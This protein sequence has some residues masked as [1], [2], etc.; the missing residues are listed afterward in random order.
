MVHSRR[1]S[2]HGHH[3][4]CHHR[5][6]RKGSSVIPYASGPIAPESISELNNRGTLIVAFGGNALAPLGG[7]ATTL[8]TETCAFTIPHDATLR[9]LFTSFVFAF[10]TA[11][12]APQTLLITATILTAPAPPSVTGVQPPVPFAPTSLT[13][14]LLLNSSNTVA[15]ISGSDYQI[16]DKTHQVR[17]V[18]GTRVA[19]EIS[20]VA[21]DGAVFN[22]SA[23]AIN[24]AVFF[25]TAN[26]T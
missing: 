6:K 13:A 1:H 2:G 3:R 11:L 12:T 15:S 4:H 10:R 14:T 9:N 22:P 7:F 18:S 26:L 5:H 17:I 19:L 16:S 25:E 21:K 20:V 8:Q 24:G 23:M